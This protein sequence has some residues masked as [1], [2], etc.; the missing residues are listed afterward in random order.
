MTL[1]RPA[2]ADRWLVHDWLNIPGI[3][4]RMMGP[5]TFPELSLPTFAEFCADYPDPIWLHSS[6]EL[7]RLFLIM[8][9]GLKVGCIIHNEIVVTAGGVSATELDL[10]LAG[11]AFMGK[12]YGR[13]AIEEMCALVARDFGVREVFLQPSARNPIACAAYA[14]AG[15]TRSLLGPVE[16]AAHYRTRPDYSDSVFFVRRL[17][18]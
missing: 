12:G 6:P 16:A 17:V 18:A 9:D 14:G 1:E 5:P 10:W 3:G 4:D 15:F 13:R 2:L 11:P 8:A 7:G